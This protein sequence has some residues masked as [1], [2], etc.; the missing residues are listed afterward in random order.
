MGDQQIRNAVAREVALDDRIVC[1]MP[2]TL[3]TAALDDLR[4]DQGLV[5]RGCGDN[6]RQQERPQGVGGE[7]SGV[8]G[9]AREGRHVGSDVSVG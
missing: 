3:G 7:T 9:R 1:T 2:R 4:R 8:A 5:V 6:G